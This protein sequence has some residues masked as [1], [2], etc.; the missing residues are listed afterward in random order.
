VILLDEN[1]P[2]SQRH[3]L[4]RQRIRARQIG[5]DVAAKGLLDDEIIPLLIRLR[6]PTFFTW[7]LGFYKRRLCHRRYCLVCLAVSRDEAAHFVRRL[8]QNA[9]FDS[10]AKRLGSVVRVSRAGVRF[11]GFSEERETVLPW[12]GSS[13]PS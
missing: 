12:V 5:V 13:R 4:N 10:R 6:R 7:D 1:I 3:L 8:L 2:E 9:R 11:W